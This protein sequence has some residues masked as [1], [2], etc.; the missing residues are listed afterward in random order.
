MKFSCEKA[1]LLNAASTA[2]RAVTAKSNIPSLEGILIEAGSQLTLTGYNLETGIRTVIPSDIAEKGSIVINAKIFVDIIRMMPDEFITVSVDNK[3]GVSVECKNSHYNII[4]IDPGEYP[5][6]PGLDQKNSLSLEQRQLRSLIGQTI[7]SSSDNES[8]PV[9]SG[10]LFEIQGDVLTVVALDGFRVALRR[11]HIT[12]E[13]AQDFSF[14]V[15]GAALKEAE[16]ISRDS[17][18][19]VQIRQGSKHVIFQFGDTTLITRLLE[20]EFLDYKNAIP[21]ANKKICVADRAD[22]KA[23]VDRVSI[24]ISDDTKTPARCKFGFGEFSIQATTTL[25]SASDR[26]VID[27]D[28]GELEIGFNSRYLLEALREIPAGKIKIELGTN[29]TPIV[30]VP[31]EGE[32]N[33]LY[34]ILPVRLKTQA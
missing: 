21:R 20:G 11:E 2:S 29:I 31:E 4:G 6:L 33:F 23:C 34:M 19:E 25:G 13:S 10:E 32:E 22:L 1:L 14:I 8:R 5:E 30:I 9:Y 17:D 12:N 3:L 15:P 18:D 28:G 27:G 26:C 7:F 16:R 24:I